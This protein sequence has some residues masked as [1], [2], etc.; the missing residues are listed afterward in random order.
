M[1]NILFVSLSCAQERFNRLMAEIK[2]L[3]QNDQ[4]LYQL[5]M[6]G[7]AKN[8]GVCVH[9]ISTLPVSR[10]NCKH[11]YIHAE[12]ADENDCHYH[13][14]AVLN[15][16]LLRNLSNCVQT[17]RLVRKLSKGQR[18]KTVV[19]CDVLNLSNAFGALLACKMIGLPCIGIVTD[20]PRK[21]ASRGNMLSRMIDSVRFAQLQSYDAY[22]FLSE[23][24]NELIN[25]ANKPYIVVEGT[26]DSEMKRVENTLQGKAKTRICVYSGSIRRIYGVPAL[27]DGFLRANLPNTELWIYG[28]GDYRDELKEICRKHSNIRYFG[29]VPNSEVVQTQIKA[30][31]LV[32]PRP[33]IG[34]YT[35]YSFPS[36]N[37][38]YLVSG[39][40]VLAAMLPG[41]PE[42]YRDYMFELK[43]CSAEGIGK[44]LNDI[45]SYSDEELLE[46]GKKAKAFVLLKKNNLAQSQRILHLATRVI[47][48]GAKKEQ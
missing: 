23:P 9:A 47:K 37:M 15:I 21:R 31:L 35:M 16:P 26:V 29:V 2:S 13:H 18:E 25:R 3:E 27:V 43:D 24:M 10:S 48:Y 44:T 42:E 36:K 41:M 6:T 22:V 20:V 11:L 5:L 45:F 1:V 46:K 8:K 33:P 32:N 30:T 38:E 34:E 7:M 39:T 14:K 19:I 40:P 17:F 28:D 4:K 12:D